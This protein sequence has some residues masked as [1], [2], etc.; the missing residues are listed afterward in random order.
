MCA[1][2]CDITSSKSYREGSTF[3]SFVKTSTIKT[4]TSKKG[5]QYQQLFIIREIG[6]FH[7]RRQL[8]PSPIFSNQLLEFEKGAQKP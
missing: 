5:F 2:A 7:L 6:H 8:Q 4:S 3:N 1:R